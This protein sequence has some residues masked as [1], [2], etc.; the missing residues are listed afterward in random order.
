MIHKCNWYCQEAMH[1]EVI[2]TTDST[3]TPET[4]LCF[5]RR[6]RAAYR[7]KILAVAPAREPA[8]TQQ[9]SRTL[10]DEYGQIGHVQWKPFTKW[11]LVTFQWDRPGKASTAAQP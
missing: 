9:E 1:C 4:V 3:H 7:A 8:R 11:W 5:L 10:I 2:G 6:Y